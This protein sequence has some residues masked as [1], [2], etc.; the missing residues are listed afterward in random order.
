MPAKKWGYRYYDR[1]AGADAGEIRAVPSLS[2][3]LAREIGWGGLRIVCPVSLRV[4]GADGGVFLSRCGRE[5]AGS[6]NLRSVISIAE[7]RLRVSRS[8]GVRA[9]LGHVYRTPRDRRDTRAGDT[10]LLSGLLGRGVRDD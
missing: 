10:L 6:G 1:C 9:G 5:T 4:A 2:E 8:G 3:R 7:Q